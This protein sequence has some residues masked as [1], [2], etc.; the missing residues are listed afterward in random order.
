MWRPTEPDDGLGSGDLDCDDVVAGRR[1]PCSDDDAA[2]QAAT[3]S[4]ITPQGQTC[5]QVARDC[6]VAETSCGTL[7]GTGYIPMVCYNFLNTG[8]EPCSCSCPPASEDC[9]ALTGTLSG[10]V[11]QRNLATLLS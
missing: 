2:M 9:T 7:G 6:P 3:I 11:R 8:N 5:A 1:P 4:L 10:P